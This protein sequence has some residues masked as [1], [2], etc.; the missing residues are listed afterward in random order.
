MKIRKRAT[1]YT[2]EMLPRNRKEV[3][4]D[5]LRLHFWDFIKLGLVM[6]LFSLPLHL[7][8]VGEDII[9]G[10]I[11][12][13]IQGAT[14]ELQQGGY[15]TILAVKILRAAVSTLLTPFFAVGLAGVLRVIRQYGWGENVFLATDFVKGV[16]QNWK[17]ITGLQFLLGLVYT[18]SLLA[19]Q[20]GDISTG[21]IAWLLHIPMAV[22][23]LVILPVAGYTMAGIPV[24]STGLL[25]HF[26]AGFQ[27]YIKKL[28]PTLF[29][30]LCSTAIYLPLLI[31]NLYV[32]IF[33]RIIA[34]LLTPIV[35][36]GWCLFCYNQQD[37]FINQTDYPE[38]IGRGTLSNM[39][40]E[41]G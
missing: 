10:S 41:Q 11:Y 25:S 8:A 12:I 7:A 15:I 27:I 3:F 6:L 23:I 37:K 38:L 28:F 24:Y 22:F 19:Q 13:Q 5:V 30:V 4:F 31:P 17:Q 33:G 26:G 29:G 14:S 40:I 9:T 18:L 35:M 2:P 39:E 1:D 16:R 20:L 32:H 21:A 34:T 36:L